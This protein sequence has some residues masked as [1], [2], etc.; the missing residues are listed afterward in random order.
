MMV[1]RLSYGVMALLATTTLTQAYTANAQDTSTAEAADDRV[2]GEVVIRG[3]FIPDEK[4][5]TSE[6]SSL[7]DAEDFSLRGDSDVAAALQRVTGVSIADGKFVYVRGLNERYASSTLNGSII[8]S[9][10]PLRKVAPLD[11]FP[12]S[13]LESTLVQKTFSPEMSAEFGGGVIDIRTKA[14]PLENFFEIGVSGGG[15]SETTFDDGFQY[16]GGDTDFLGYDDGTRNLPE[17]LG[18]IFANGAYGSTPLADRN[19]FARALTRDASLLVVQE[20]DVGADVGVDATVGRRYD[21]N[22][23]LSFGFLGYGSYSNEWSTRDGVQGIGQALLRQGEPEGP[24]LAL[25]QFDRRSTTNTIGANGLLSIGA[26]IFDNHSVKALAF[27][28]RSTD[29]ETEVAEGFTN[30]DD[31]VRRESLEWIERQLWTTQIQGEHEFPDFADL[32]VDWRGSY[33]EANR[34]APYQVFHEY[35]LLPSTDEFALRRGSSIEFS[36]INDDTTDFGVDFVLPLS[37]G[38]VDVDLKAGYLY[39]EKDR[40]SQTDALVALDF[41]VEARSLR[42][43]FAYQQFFS[44]PSTSFVATR[45]AQSPSF[46]V[47]T[48]EVDAGYVGVDAQLTQFL[49]V[50]VGGRYEDFIQAVETRLGA[51]TAGIITPALEDDTFYPAATVTWNFAD[52]LQLRMGYSETVNRP[53]FREFGPSRFTNTETNE[54]FSGNPFL[55]S[56]DITNYD[57]RLEY[58]FGRDQFVTLG[59]FRKELENPIEAF[60]VGSGESRLVTFVNIDEAEVEG[61]EVEY[62]QSILFGDWIE[63]DWFKSKDFTFQANYTYS[64]SSIDATSPVIFLGQSASAQL[65]QQ[66]TGL[67]DSVVFSLEQLRA[68]GAVDERIAD[69]DPDRQLQGQSEHL[70][71]IQIGYSDIE[72]GSDLNLLVNVQS[73]RIRSVESFSDDSPAIIEQP[74]FTVDLIYK[75]RFELN[76]G[77]YKFSFKVE[78][79][80][81]DQYKAFQEAGGSKVIVDRYDVGQSLS[82]SLT[83]TF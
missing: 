16:D 68:S 46:Y 63:S 19:A 54:Q 83:R 10:A 17:G 4:R 50:A 72:A 21:V 66:L 29:K 20:G 25:S 14:V 33:S 34:D 2:L 67:T 74:P 30:D 48:Q 23:D 31:D 37:F 13:V 7:L 78:N 80:L 53:Q 45:S 56:T 32:R 79:I 1:N 26:D 38:S 36:E 43:D 15:N 8:P 60:N 82:V 69:F 18:D 24:A 76:G 61:F 51:N 42:V 75:R 35:I 62:Q 39:T 73:E 6:V 41:P 57:A 11:L 27:G 49:R 3:E 28:T 59:V 47:A 65:V 12:T 52:D 71:N 44:D 5:E 64:D 22:N 77:D 58:Y 55:E 40:S 70:G 81:G 9:P